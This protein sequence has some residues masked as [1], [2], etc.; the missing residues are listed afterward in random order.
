MDPSENPPCESFHEITLSQINPSRKEPLKLF[1]PFPVI[2]ME[3]P[4][5]VVR[6]DRYLDL[7]LK[8]AMFEPWPIDFSGRCKMDVRNWKPWVEKSVERSS[9]ALPVKSL[10]RHLDSQFPSCWCD[11]HPSLPYDSALSRVRRL[12]RELYSSP[13]ELV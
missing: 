11:I 6:G 4:H 13:K 3:E 9:T 8:K 10:E 12:I 1:F 5:A 2:L 7:V